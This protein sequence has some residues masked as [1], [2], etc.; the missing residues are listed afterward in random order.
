MRQ[1]H[2]Q[3]ILRAPAVRRYSAVRVSSSWGARAVPVVRRSPRD[4]TVENL[5]ITTDEHARA[6]YVSERI[7]PGTSRLDYLT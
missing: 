6:M 5:G 4:R 2:R 3:A 1:A 7:R